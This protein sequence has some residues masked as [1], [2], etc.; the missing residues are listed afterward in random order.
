MQRLLKKLDRA[1]LDPE[2]VHDAIAGACAAHR[3]GRAI[4]DDMTLVVARVRAEVAA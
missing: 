4:A 3:A 1:R 2:S